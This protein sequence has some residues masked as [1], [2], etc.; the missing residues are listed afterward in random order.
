MIVVLMVFMVAS[1]F[2]LKGKNNS[3]NQLLRLQRVASAFFLKGKNNPLAYIDAN[4]S[5]CIC[6]LF[7]R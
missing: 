2:F 3:L 4:N 1:A 5:S 6:L 7:E